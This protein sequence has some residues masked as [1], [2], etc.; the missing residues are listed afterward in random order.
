MVS[1]G[2]GTIVTD[3]ARFDD[4]AWEYVS[5]MSPA[6][7]KSA[8]KAAFESRR[9]AHAAGLEAALV[10]IVAPRAAASAATEIAR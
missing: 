6:A 7:G 10:R 4:A 2:C 5:Q 1:A 8:V 9:L 3:G